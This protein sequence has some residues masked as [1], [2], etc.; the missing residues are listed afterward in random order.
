MRITS[1]PK[2][3]WRKAT[4]GF[5]LIELLIVVAIILIIAAIAIPSFMRSRMAANE[6]AAVEN[7]RT[8]T[9]GSVVY[10]T[11]YGNGFPPNLNTLGGTV[12]AT[13]DA[14]V[15]LSTLLTTPPFQASGYSFT[16]SPQGAPVVAPVGC[17]TA[18]Y[19]A[20]L[21]VALPINLGVTGLRSFCTSEPGVI[22]FDI[23]GSPIASPVACQALPVLQ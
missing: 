8:I 16:Y 11:T 5:S 9:T 12:P 6:S 1:Y 3:S 7:L 20:Y 21:A 10:N 15:L 17:S 13:C 23:T 22:H 18:G 19:G 4:A 14:A 2:E